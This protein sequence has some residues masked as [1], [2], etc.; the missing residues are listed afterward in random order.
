MRRLALV[1]LCTCGPRTL[2]VQMT[3]ENNSGQSGT[4]TLTDQGKKTGV[5]IEIRRSVDPQVKRQ[6]VHFHPGR[7]GEIDAKLADDLAGLP[8]MQDPA[9]FGKPSDG[10]TVYTEATISVPFTELTNGT[11][12]INVHDARDFGLY[13]A[14]GNIN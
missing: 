5:A 1:L 2:V 12:V 10:G 13:V 7:C 9:E 3:A 4:A 11:N 8:D 6:A 14:C